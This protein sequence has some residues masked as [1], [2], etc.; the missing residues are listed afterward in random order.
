MLV[1]C[2]PGEVN[3]SVCW[4]ISFRVRYAK[5]CQR[6]QPLRLK[7]GKLPEASNRPCVKHLSPALS[8]QSLSK[9]AEEKIHILAFVPAVGAIP[10]DWRQCR[11]G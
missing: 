10:F 11:A 8:G 9:A 3:T 7:G 1:S 4:E 6:L 2:S 5:D